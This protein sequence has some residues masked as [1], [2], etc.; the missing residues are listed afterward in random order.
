MYFND[1]YLTGTLS[2][3]TLRIASTLISSLNLLEIFEA[4]LPGRNID[5]EIN[6]NLSKIIRD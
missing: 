4:A 3:L 1:V 5:R 6:Y 2:Q